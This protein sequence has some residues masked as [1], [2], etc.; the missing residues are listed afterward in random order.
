MTCRLSDLKYKE[1]INLKDGQRLGC[2]CDA[3]ID[4]ESGQITALV[5]PGPCRVMGMFLR[6]EDYVLPWD[7]ITRLGDDILLVDM[8]LTPRKP[9]REKRNWL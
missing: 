8:P 1:V 2:V 4:P 6:E 7:C 3:E 9:R 5:V